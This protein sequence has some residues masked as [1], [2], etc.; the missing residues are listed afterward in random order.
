MKYVLIDNLKIL[1]S[2]IRECSW[3]IVPCPIF[4]A[5]MFAHK[6]GREINAFPVGI[7]YI[8]KEYKYNGIKEYGNLKSTNV[9]G[10]NNINA[11]IFHKTPGAFLQPNIVGDLMIS[12]VLIFNDDANINV[13]DI[14][15]AIRHSKF[16]GGDI[17]TYYVNDIV[18]DV[19]KLKHLIKGG[20]YLFDRKDLLEN[21]TNRLDTLITNICSKKESWLIPTK[22]GYLLAETPKIRKGIR[23]NHNYKHALVEPLLGLVQLISVRQCNN[24]PFWE[25]SSVINKAFVVQQNKLIGE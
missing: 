17:I 24:L 1:D 7:S 20:F 13:D 6:I 12:L 8:H 19:D 3:L 23:E 4:Q 16:A 25:Y 11:D 18:N 15:S 2:N 22:M 21:S 5:S 9:A 10:F 14:K